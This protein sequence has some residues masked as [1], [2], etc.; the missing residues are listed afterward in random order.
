MP[1]LKAHASRCSRGRGAASWKNW[2]NERNIAG[3]KRTLRSSISLSKAV[4][5]KRWNLPGERWPIEWIDAQ[6]AVEVQPAE[7]LRLLGYPRGFELEGRAR[8]LADWAFAWYAEHGKPWVY[9]R[10]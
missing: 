2:S 5:S 1:L 7:Y 6:P 3:W 10:E 8:E 9:A 4:S